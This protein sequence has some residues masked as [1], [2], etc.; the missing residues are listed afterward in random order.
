MIIFF[1]FFPFA[2]CTY[3]CNIF[4]FLFTAHY[5]IPIRDLSRRIRDKENLI[6][7]L[8]VRQRDIIF[9]IGLR[10]ANVRSFHRKSDFPF[11]WSFIQSPYCCLSSLGSRVR[12]VQCPC[13]LAT[14]FPMAS[15]NRFLT[16]T[17]TPTSD[18]H[19]KDSLA[20]SSPLVLKF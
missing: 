19:S 5:L 15:P 1:I 9:F 20:S 16:P 18:S 7:N 10:S 6:K 11:V 14:G 8:L 2:K 17:L 3:L 12:A 13:R 4:S